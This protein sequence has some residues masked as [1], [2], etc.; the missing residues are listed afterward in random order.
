LPGNVAR[1]DLRQAYNAGT[2]DSDTVLRA[3]M[4]G[5]RAFVTGALALLLLRPET[6]V[7]R[8]L[9]LQTPRIVA[10]LCWKAGLSA[11]CCYH[12]QLKVAGI[13]AVR[14]LEPRSGEY[15][16]PDSQMETLWEVYGVG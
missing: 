14:A 9:R 2:L 5:Q 13:P 3:I 1:E 10:A 6:L 11:T 16:L 8:L 15:P 12:V 7:H 4:G